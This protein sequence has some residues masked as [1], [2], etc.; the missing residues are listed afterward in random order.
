MSSY[1]TAP[2]RE[3]APERRRK[4]LFDSASG[5]AESARGYLANARGGLNRVKGA[6]DEFSDVYGDAKS[7][8]SDATSAVNYTA[9]SPVGDSLNYLSGGWLDRLGLR[10]PD[11]LFGRTLAFLSGGRQ[12]AGSPKNN[13]IYSGQAQ[14]SDSF[15]DYARDSIGSFYSDTVPNISDLFAKKGALSSSAYENAVSR[16][17]D[18]L[19]K[20]LRR[21]RLDYDL[22]N[23][24]IEAKNFATLASM[25][26]GRQNPDDDFQY[27]VPEDV[28]ADE[29]SFP[30]PGQVPVT[31]MT[32]IEPVSSYP[33]K[34][35]LRANVGRGPEVIQGRQAASRAMLDRYLQGDPTDLKAIARYKEAGGDKDMVSYFLKQRE[36][37]AVAQE[38]ELEDARQ[39]NLSKQSKTQ[40]LLRLRAPLLTEIPTA[41]GYGRAF[42]Q[43]LGIPNV[44]SRSVAEVESAV[45]QLFL[46]DLSQIGQTGTRGNQFLEKVLANALP[47]I[48][49]SAEARQSLYNGLALMNQI[50]IAKSDIQLKYSAMAENESRLTNDRDRMSMA[51]ELADVSSY[52][53][54]PFLVAEGD[55]SAK[56]YTSE[57]KKD[58]LNGPT[59]GLGTEYITESLVHRTMEKTGK[60]ER[61]AVAYLA[62]V[63]YVTPTLDNHQRELLDRYYVYKPWIST[64]KT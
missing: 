35:P 26:R 39:V 54:L 44:N 47:K 62:G 36:T 53:E 49:D 29:Q 16:T 58:F 37:K 10:D 55:L 60:D 51:K 48:T 31:G 64:P 2:G 32:P 18:D 23:K 25:N 57:F 27:Q 41:E 9:N 38:K 3:L 7:L 56:E 22:R 34:R 6:F 61:E 59:P 5:L 13:N 28:Q 45:K 40:N 42:F 19:F 63:G 15:N 52:Y 4:D 8:A 17:R 50:R 30:F 1:T 12:Q 24:A 33:T 11:S 14:P 21:E 20:S 43:R 46:E